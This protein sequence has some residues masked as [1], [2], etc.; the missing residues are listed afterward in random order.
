M[1]GLIGV[2][3]GGSG[4]KGATVDS[5]RGVLTSDRIRVATPQP[6]TPE[7]VVSATAALIAE[8]GP[9]EGPVGVGLPSPIVGGVAMAAANIHKSWIGVNAVEAFSEAVGRPVVVLNDA[10]AAGL[11][12]VRFGAGKGVT[13]V[14][15]MLTLGTGIG[16]ALFV[17]GA[18]VPNLE[19]GHI[20]IRGKDAERRASAGA[21]ERKGLSYSQWAPLLNEYLDRIDQLI[22]PDLV[23][24]GG[25]VSKREDKFLPLL[26]VR[27]PVV[28][29]TLRNEAGIVGTAMRARELLPARRSATAS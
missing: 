15:L 18:L 11:A 6:A 26:D 2:D 8:L 3:I 29:A 27:P 23:I 12:E 17:D 7:A 28:P 25:G 5:R 1:R 24:L 9:D 4:I 19:L 16:S 20:E 13:G 10:D 21:R 22:W 14:V